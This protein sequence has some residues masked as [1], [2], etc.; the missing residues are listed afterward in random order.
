MKLSNNIG[1]LLNHLAFVLGRQSDQVLLE[2]LGI[3]FSQFKILMVLRWNPHIQQRVIAERLGQTEASISRQIKLLLGQGFL[4]SEKR[5]ENRREHITALTLK[6]ERFIDEAMSILNSYH[7]PVFESLSE[8]QQAVV[9]A[10]L[11]QM[12]EKACES[13]K[14]GACHHV[15][16][17]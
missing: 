3:G 7:A 4:Q 14:P 12:H 1:Y 8:K 17:N 15:F 16:D 6:G 5:P 9:L 10:S 11:Q 13:D 2:R